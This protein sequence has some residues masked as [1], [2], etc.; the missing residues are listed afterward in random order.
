VQVSQDDKVAFDWTFQTNKKYNRCQAVFTGTGF[1]KRNH[2][3]PLFR[4]PQQVKFLTSVAAKQ[5]RKGEIFM[6]S[7]VYTDTCPHNEEFWKRFWNL[8]A[9]RPSTLY[10]ALIH[11]VMDTLDSKCQLYWKAWIAAAWLQFYSR[12]IS[13]DKKPP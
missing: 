13:E 6:Q 7:S 3:A 4:P 10:F 12:L 5:R 8:P 9:W 11:R 2:Y 1:D